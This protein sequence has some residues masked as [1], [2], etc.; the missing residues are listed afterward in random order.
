MFGPKDLV[1]ALGGEVQESTLHS[2]DGVL[3]AKTQTLGDITISSVT[4][5]DPNGDLERYTV[6]MSPEA[7]VEITSRAYTHTMPDGTVAVLILS[8]IYGMTEDA[9]IEGTATDIEV[10]STSY[11]D[12]SDLIR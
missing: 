9:T 4:L 7:I 6:Y 10:V 5:I 2:V 1:A 3:K 12:L 8:D 11:D